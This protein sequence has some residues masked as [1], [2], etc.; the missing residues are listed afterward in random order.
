LK[1]IPLISS[2][3]HINDHQYLLNKK[4]TDEQTKI[5]INENDLDYYIPP[6]LYG[7]CNR[8]CTSNRK[9]HKDII[10]IKIKTKK[11]KTIPPL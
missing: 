7:T 8:V 11:E 2:N 5:H 6:K 9:E 3:Y 4:Q 1:I 10:P